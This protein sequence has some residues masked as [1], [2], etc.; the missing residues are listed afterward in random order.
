M[1][2]GEITS[3]ELHDLLMHSN[4]NFSFFV[5]SCTVTLL[6]VL[7]LVCIFN[8]FTFNK[9]RIVYLFVCTM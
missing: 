6:P 1:K 9:S 8:F 2:K 5:T 4:M 7:H 3:D